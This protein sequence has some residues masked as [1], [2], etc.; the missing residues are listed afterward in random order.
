MAGNVLQ[1]GYKMDMSVT[2]TV[3][4]YICTFLVLI[5]A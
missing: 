2:N 5:K 3:Q 4:L 1:K